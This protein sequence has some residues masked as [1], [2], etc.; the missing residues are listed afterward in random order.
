M[1]VPSA[2]LRAVTRPATTV[3]RGRK[4]N[5]RRRCMG[6]RP[7]SRLPSPRPSRCRSRVV[8]ETRTG[9]ERSRARR[10]D[11]DRH[12]PPQALHNRLPIKPWRAAFRGLR[13]RPERNG[14]GLQRRRPL[15]PCPGLHRHRGH[16]RG[17]HLRGLS[18]APSRSAMPA[19]GDSGSCCR[20]PTP[21]LASLV[22]DDA[23][24]NRH[25]VEGHYRN[26]RRDD[27]DDRDIIRVWFTPAT[28][29]SMRRRDLR[30]VLKDAE[31]KHRTCQKQKFGRLQVSP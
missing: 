10:A 3:D 29:L 5:R 22:L 1:D 18:K 2:G 9:T 6:G 15:R 7:S 8:A 4:C 21:R 16:N 24:T 19:A 31:G 25:S 26:H 27:H 14:I 23:Q 30:G 11:R 13:A 17:D 28:T 12:G 20:R